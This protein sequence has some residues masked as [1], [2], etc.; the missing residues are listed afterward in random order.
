MYPCESDMVQILDKA[1]AVPD[2]EEAVKW[3][4]GTVR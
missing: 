1:M 2:K 4:P 3:V